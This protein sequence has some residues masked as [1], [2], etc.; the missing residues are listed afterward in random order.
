[1]RPNGVVISYVQVVGGILSQ[2]TLLNRSQSETNSTNP[3]FSM[4]V[5]RYNVTYSVLDCG[6]GIGLL[7]GS[8]DNNNPVR[9]E[10]VSHEYLA[11]SISYKI[12][13]ISRISPP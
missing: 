6:F 8:Y 10:Q 12:N 9:V 11:S 13:I 7:T 1:M 3:Y 4:V 2:P 5:S